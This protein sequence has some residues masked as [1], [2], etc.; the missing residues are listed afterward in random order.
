MDDLNQHSEP[1]TVVCAACE[2]S[3]VPGPF[4]RRCGAPL[5]EVPYVQG[6]PEATA[7]RGRVR[8][9]VVAGLVATVCVLAWRLVCW[10]VLACS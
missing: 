3:V 6:A 2:A 7:A 9:G 8:R 4:C 10:S 1:E 5:Q